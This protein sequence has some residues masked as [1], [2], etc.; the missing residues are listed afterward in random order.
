M[1][2]FDQK[3]M[4]NTSIHPITSI[5]IDQDLCTNLDNGNNTFEFKFT[6]AIHTTNTTRMSVANFSVPYS[7]FNITAALGNN[8]YEYIWYD[9]AVTVPAESGTAFTVTMPDGYYD[10]STLNAYLQFT[11]IKNGH[12][13]IDDN[14]NYV[15]FLE[16]VNNTTQYRTQINSYKLPGLPLPTGWIKGSGITLTPWISGHTFP[17][18]KI[19]LTDTG[20]GATSTG[21]VVS[22]F[23][24][25]GLLESGQTTPPS[26]NPAYTETFPKVEPAVGYNV[27]SYVGDISPSQTQVHS[28]CLTCE[29]DVCSGSVIT[30]LVV[31]FFLCFHSYID[32][33]LRS[34]SEHPVSTF[35]VTTQNVSVPFGSDIANSNF[36]TT[37]IPLLGNQTISKLVFKLLDQ[38]GDAV[39]LEDPDTNIELLI[40]DLRY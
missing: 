16:F 10:T 24:Y 5:F 23:V 18:P 8:Q 34:T 30:I 31:L 19:R 17:C 40:T 27:S 35:V 26:F 15:Y 29:Y 21:N 33:P 6:R 22:L 7:W 9:G 12:Y 28:I 36:F 13:M 4:Q 11:M 1:V 37:W 20:K 25:F 38:E 2:W 39:H 14:G 3:K 32:N